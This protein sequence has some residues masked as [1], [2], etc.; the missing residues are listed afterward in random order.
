MLVALAILLTAGCGSQ[1]RTAHVS[2]LLR[3]ISLPGG[4]Q[5]TVGHRAEAATILT[6]SGANARDAG[7]V[8]VFLHGWGPTTPVLYPA[9]LAHLVD[10]GATVIFPAYQSERLSQLLQNVQDAVRTALEHLPSRP[11]SLILAGHTTG[12]TLALDYASTAAYTGLPPACAIYGVFPATVLG[13]RG[14]L[15]LANLS[16]IPASTLLTLVGGRSDPVLSG[17]SPQQLLKDASRVPAAHRTLL[18]PGED[19]GGP[20]ESTAASQRT[21]WKPLDELIA[22]CTRTKR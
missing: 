20:T 14:N 21:Y 9:W 8:V 6:P 22:R 15:P 17:E 2:A 10:E 13:S 11:R 4:T 12:A 7:S 19:S 16:A 3:P 18:E 1:H 5:Q